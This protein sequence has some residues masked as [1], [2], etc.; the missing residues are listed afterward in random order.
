MSLRTAYAGGTRLC[1]D[2]IVYAFDDFVTDDECRHI[3][4]IA[5]PHLQR[6]QVSGVNGGVQ[7]QGRSNELTWLPHDTDDVTTAITERV[8]ALVGL[9][10]EN[11]ESMQVIRYSPGQE[12]RHH[13]DAYN[14]GSERGRRCCSRGG[15]RL[16]TTLIYLSDVEEGGC[17]GFPRLG[18]A[19]VPRKRTML[20]FHNCHQGTTYV[21]PDTLHAGLP[22][23]RGEKWAVNLWFR[24]RPYRLPG[25]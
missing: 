11:A 15:Q 16:V 6:G 7:S 21:H 19:V 22:V 14:L 12:Y 2:P 23:I 24:E 5:R 8:A 18:M 4:E 3:T 13:F 1:E 10:A 9:P 17:T 25:E 20:L